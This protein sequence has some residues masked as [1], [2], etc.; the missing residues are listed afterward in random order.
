VIKAE[1]LA[2]IRRIEE[3]HTACGE[4]WELEDWIAQQLYDHYKG[5]LHY[6][7]S[8]FRFWDAVLIYQSCRSQFSIT[9]IVGDSVIDRTF[10]VSQFLH[11]N[12]GIEELTE[13]NAELAFSESDFELMAMQMTEEIV[14]WYDNMTM[15]LS[16]FG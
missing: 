11:T 2:E 6:Y 15:V 5:D 10:P 8:G 14:S 3:L 13:V 12:Y 1:E 16:V 4:R 9:R 7:F